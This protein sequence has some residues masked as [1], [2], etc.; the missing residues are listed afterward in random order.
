MVSRVRTF[1][2]V[3]IAAALG[4]IHDAQADTRCGWIGTQVTPMTEAFA[5]SLGMAVPHG[6]IFKQPQPGSPAAQRKIHA[7]DV[8]T[9]MN[10]IPIKNPRDFERRILAMAPGASVHLRVFRNRQPIMFTVPLG[11]TKCPQPQD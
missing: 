4:F 11:S 8:V 3:L 9:T 10:G 1:I 5:V 2:C 7:G 6:A